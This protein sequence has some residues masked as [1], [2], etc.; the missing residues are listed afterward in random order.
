MEIIDSNNYE[1]FWNR[2]IGKKKVNWSQW[3]IMTGLESLVV[4]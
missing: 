2:I 3:M 1:E 4:P